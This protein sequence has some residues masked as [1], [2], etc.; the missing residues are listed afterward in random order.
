MTD[1]VGDD[2]SAR[3]L[4]KALK[5]R[6]QLAATAAAIA[7]TEDGI[8]DT[9][10]HLARV[11]PHDAERLRA[12]AAHARTFAARERAQAAIYRAP[13]D[14]IPA[15]GNRVREGDARRAVNMAHTIFPASPGSV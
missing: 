14:G 8:A 7:E 9:L 10:D 5:L 3:A 2:S 13:P 6:Q 15:G 4:S 11:R 1:R 12:R